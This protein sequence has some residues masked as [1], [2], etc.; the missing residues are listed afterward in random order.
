MPFCVAKELSP[1]C[2]W[3]PFVCSFA[4]SLASNASSL[5]DSRQ[6]AAGSGQRAAGTGQKVANGSVKLL[7]ACRIWCMVVHAMCCIHAT[8]ATLSQ[9]RVL[10]QLQS[11]QFTSPHLI[12]S[13][14]RVIVA[15]PGRCQATSLSL[16]SSPATAHL[17]EICV[18]LSM[19]P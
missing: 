8:H 14:L 9:W 3:R 12:A 15:L 16:P 4:T 6:Q 1:H 11:P 10:C 7:A 19:R 18:R 17:Q 2:S 13:W 5:V